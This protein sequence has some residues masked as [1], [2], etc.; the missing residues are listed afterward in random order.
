MSVTIRTPFLVRNSKHLAM[1][2]SF[3]KRVVGA[4]AAPCRVSWAGKNN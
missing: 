1:L 3:W 4:R 2:R